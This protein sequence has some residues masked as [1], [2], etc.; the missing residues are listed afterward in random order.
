MSCPI[1]EASFKATLFAKGLR[2][3]TAPTTSGRSSRSSSSAGISRSK[4]RMV[5]DLGSSASRMACA[6][7]GDDSLSDRSLPVMLLGLMHITRSPARRHFGTGDW[8]RSDSR[9]AALC[10]PNNGSVARMSTSGGTSFRISL[11]GSSLIETTF[12]TGVPGRTVFWPSRSRHGEARTMG[13]REQPIRSAPHRTRR[14]PE[15]QA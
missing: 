9:A 12:M 10:G 2:C 5:T 11:A 8:T 3:R 15:G 4:L 6:K 14:I 7:R 1:P 13:P